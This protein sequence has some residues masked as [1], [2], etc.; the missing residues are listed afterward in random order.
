MHRF[1]FIAASSFLIAGSWVRFG[2]AQEYRS[3]VTATDF[4]YV[5]ADD[6]STFK[7]LT[8]LERQHA[9]M[10]DK[11]E[12]HDELR[13][14]AF[15]FDASFSDNTSVKIFIDAAFKTPEAAEQEAKRYVDP[16]G[17]LPTALR[18]GVNRLVVHAGGEDTTAFSDIGLI[19]L[20]ADNAT[21]R[22]ST[23]DLEETTFHESVHAAWDNKHAKSE[24]WVRAQAADGTFVTTYAK[25]QPAR[26]DLAESALFA[27]TL[28]HHPG[29]IPKEHAVKIKKAIPNRIRYVGE[30]IPVGKPVFYD[31]T[32][33]RQP[34]WDQRRDG[35]HCDIRIVGVFADVMSN[36]LSQEFDLE[37]QEINRVTTGAGNRFDSSEELFQEVVSKFKLSPKELKAALVKQ[38]HCNC[39]HK[40]VDDAP[41]RVFIESFATERKI[42]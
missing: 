36:A 20:Y 39:K 30:L 38:L 29:R 2:L 35:V 21:K 34:I 11:R 33:T 26:E 3:S 12:G 17:K 24:G 28:L 27:Y 41:A 5:T 40:S 10:P 14:D 31:T 25:K 18:S 19:V 1:L 16:L 15:V 8:Y 23:H 37:E 4:D 13:K 22:I 9:E 7:T 42:D 32:Q 6:P